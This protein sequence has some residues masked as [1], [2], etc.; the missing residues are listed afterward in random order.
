[1]SPYHRLT[2]L[3]V[4]NQT[5]FKHLQKGLPVAGPRGRREE[6][7][8]QTGRHRFAKHRP[9]ET[10]P[11]E[12]I[13]TTEAFVGIGEF[14]GTNRG[15]RHAEIAE[16]REE[17]VGAGLL[18][19]RSR[20]GQGGLNREERFGMGEEKGRVIVPLAKVPAGKSRVDLVMSRA[21]R[22]PQNCVGAQSANT[23]SKMRSMR[24]KW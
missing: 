12:D 2:A 11:L 9:T 10:R 8:R 15:Q 19:R 13:G 3:N 4:R 5:V 24:R 6:A 1:M 7:Y 16:I 17:Q 20:R 23:R 21:R 22:D 18:D 14:E